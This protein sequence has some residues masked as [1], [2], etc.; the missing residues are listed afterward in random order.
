M[1]TYR[2]HSS[3]QRDVRPALYNRVG[4]TSGPLE[5]MRSWSSSHVFKRGLSGNTKSPA[6]S[7]SN[8]LSD[9]Q[10]ETFEFG[11]ASSNPHGDELYKRMYSLGP[12]PPEV[13][14]LH[15]GL[16]HKM[17]VSNRI[18]WQPF[19]AILTKQQ[20]SLG[21]ENSRFQLGFIGVDSIVSVVRT[22]DHREGSIEAIFANST[23]RRAKQPLSASASDER[24]KRTG[25][26]RRRS[27]LG[28]AANTAAQWEDLFGGDSSGVSPG[29]DFVIT[30][31][32]EQG[33]GRSQ[34]FRAASVEECEAWIE[35]LHLAMENNQREKVVNKVSKLK[36]LANFRNRSRIILKS[37]QF[38]AF[39]TLVILAAFVTSLIQAEMLPP[40]GSNTDRLFSGLETA[41]TLLF[42][43]ELTC[44]IFAHSGSRRQFWL[45]IT[46]PW[47][48]FDMIIV[49]IGLTAEVVDN[50]PGLNVLRLFRV[51]RIVRLFKWL[52]SL[53]RVVNAISAAM[54]P[55]L[56]TFLILFLAT[57]IYAV[58]GTVLFKDRD[59]ELFGRFSASLFTMFQILTGD[60]WGSYVTRSLW[61]DG[62]TSWNGFVSF[63]FISYVLL[64][65]IILVNIV[66]AVLLDEFISSVF[67]DKQRKKQEELDKAEKVVEGVL[68]PL[69]RV[70]VHFNS[71][72]DLALHIKELFAMLDT[73]ENGVLDYAE[74]R[75]GLHKLKLASP[76]ELTPDDYEMLTE[77]GRLCVQGHNLDCCAFQVVL[78]LQIEQY[79]HR[80]LLKGMNH[81][82]GGDQHLFL[83]LK[84]LMMSRNG[85][86]APMLSRQFSY[87]LHGPPALPTLELSP[88]QPTLP[89]SGSKIDGRL[90][91]NGVTDSGNGNGHLW[92]KRGSEGGG[93]SEG[94]GVQSNGGKNPEEARGRS[95]QQGRSHEHRSKSE[96]GEGEKEHGEE[97]EGRAHRPRSHDS[98][99]RRASAHHHH[100]HANGHSNGTATPIVASPEQGHMSRHVHA[101]YNLGYGAPL[102][103]ALLPA[104]TSERAPNLD[105]LLLDARIDGIQQSVA[106][107][108]Q[109]QAHAWQQQQQTQL[110]VEQIAKAL[111]SADKLA[112]P[113]LI[114]SLPSSSPGHPR[115]SSSSSSHPPPSSASPP[116]PIL[117][118]PSPHAPPPA[119]LRMHPRRASHVTAEVGHVT[120]TPPPASPARGPSASEGN[121]NLKQEGLVPREPSVPS[122][123]SQILQPPAAPAPASPPPNPSIA[124]SGNRTLA[125]PPSP[126]SPFSFRP[127]GLALPTMPDFAPPPEIFDSEAESFAIPSPAARD[128]RECQWPPMQRASDGPDSALH[129]VALAQ[130]RSSSRSANPAGSAQESPIP[131][132]RGEGKQGERGGWAERGFHEPR[133]EEQ[134]AGG[135]EWQA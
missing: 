1:N 95:E 32:N 52:T 65:G 41:F 61:I 73:N 48:I 8:S 76:I 14:H 102:A 55:V 35:G 78:M 33:V 26:G 94:R 129:Q 124:S 134:P 123:V 77:G 29:T 59:E 53:R 105:P 67:W 11:R 132:P 103:S 114:P 122:P 106:L 96:D 40:Q 83:A 120:S 19:M 31:A 27:T 70:L 125:E 24:M 39:V 86:P 69:L 110:R 84:M 135:G 91:E 126:N 15:K 98:T 50:F 38:Q 80:Q 43:T 57:C 82:S 36:I 85:P 46:D 131:L 37:V 44:N 22:E 90:W 107:I 108:L 116:T 3:S 128:H 45:Y 56:N 64:V 58:L 54:V 74:L 68:D 20:L 111:L 115:H 23:I 79:L 13:E 5:L 99:H 42:T 119:P 63:F 28:G 4:A 47:N 2:Q 9:G 93:G 30:T 49:C 62:K 6:S 92:E 113:S 118:H 51:F 75:D 89:L 130:K 72:D 104:V 88:V 71:P 21:K 7:R 10:S 12:L 121:L 112:P 16:L 127:G 97:K 133:A 81:S 87:Q 18:A 17:V 66:V 100:A 117:T 25:S 101:S 34:Y 60:A 109:Q